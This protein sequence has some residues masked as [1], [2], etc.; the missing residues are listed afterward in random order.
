MNIQILYFASLAEKLDCSQERLE[1]AHA[2][3]T[4]AQLKSHLAER[5]EQWQKAL[6]DKTTR[7]SVNQQLS[8]DEANIPNGAEIAFFPPVT[9]G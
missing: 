7:C 5:G 6:Y 1:L 4:V 2:A 3:L 9:G 8:Q